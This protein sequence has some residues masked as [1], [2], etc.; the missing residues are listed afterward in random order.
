MDRY[1]EKAF[2]KGNIQLF[3]GSGLSSGLYPNAEEFREELLNDR[4]YS[5]DGKEFVLKEYL[6]SDESLSPLEDIAQFY[7]G[8]HKSE[9]LI[10]IIKV[11][12]GQKK[13]SIKLHQDLWSL[14]N[15]QW[16]YTTNYDCLIEEAIKRPIQEPIVITDFS[17]ANIR[18][19]DPTRRVVFKL[20]GC[21]KRSN[22]REEFVIT[23]NDY[24][25]YSYQ[26]TLEMLKTLY[27]ISTKIF[28]FI[29][30]SLKDLNM[31][32][33]ITEANR[34]ANVRSYA[35][36]ADTSK[37]EAKYWKDLNVT[38]IY[39]NADEFLKDV[40]QSFHI[41]ESEY[42][43][44]LN[45]RV[46]EKEEIANK[47][48]KVIKDEL[49]ITESKGLDIII[50]AGTTSIYL[51]KALKREIDENEEK[52]KDLIKRM[53]IITNS[54]TVVSEM[55][56]M[57]RRP[58][59]KIPLICIAGQLRYETQ[60]FIPDEESINAQL[61]LF[62]NNENKMIA[63]IGTTSIDAERL[64]TRTKEEV[65]VKKAFIQFADEVYVLADHS[66]LRYLSPS[67]GEEF[68]PLEKRMYII[69]DRVEAM[70]DLKRYVEDEH[71]I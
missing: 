28:L 65:P 68:S 66:K 33:I 50:D 56:K 10:D 6:K 8:Y 51:A 44:K 38:L 69:T 61:S 45:Q 30:Y 32:Y 62:N 42:I 64:K 55:S 52:Y 17:S 54:P 24:L 49:K 15:I 58:E 40:F 36:L 37:A 46:E 2:E 27:D 59:Q 29:G 7:E 21:A 16:I 3:I 1:L 5:D 47:A 48:L 14:P 60:A 39:M 19:I 11:F 71:I 63:F 4:R 12:Y 23:R 67:I 31:R 70:N 41:D 53:R 43:T 34:I 35:V 13:A 9:D 20:H 18:N 26:R 25:G 57:I 22:R